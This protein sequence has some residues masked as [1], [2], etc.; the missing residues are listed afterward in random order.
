MSILVSLLLLF[1]TI[2]PVASA[3]AAGE[4][5]VTASFNEYDMIKTLRVT[6]EK[7]QNQKADPHFTCRSAQSG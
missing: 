2:M 5:R 4:S 7:R 3:T 6:V 1:V